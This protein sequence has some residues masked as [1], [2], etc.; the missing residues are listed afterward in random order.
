MRRKTGASGYC[1]QCCSEHWG[2][3][4]NYGLLRVRVQELN[5]WIIWQLYFQFHKNSPHCSLQWFY[6]FTFPQTMQEIFLFSTPSPAFTVDDGHLSSVSRYLIVLLIFISLVIRHF[7]H[8]FTCLLA[9]CMS[10]LEKCL[11]RPS[12]HVLIGFFFFIE[13]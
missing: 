2:A 5:C 7:E 13:P 3:F 4:W 9:I 12:V 8:V 6:Q 1:Q 11:F 10:S